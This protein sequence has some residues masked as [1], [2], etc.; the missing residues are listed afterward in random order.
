MFWDSS[1]RPSHCRRSAR[2]WRLLSPAGQ[3]SADY[4]DDPGQADRA[5]SA[6]QA[7]VASVRTLPSSRWTALVTSSNVAA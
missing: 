5:C 3:A 4:R 7:A 2:A 6:W 1:L